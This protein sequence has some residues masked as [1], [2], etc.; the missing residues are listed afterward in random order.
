MSKIYEWLCNLCF[1]KCGEYG[2]LRVRKMIDIERSIFSILIYVPDVRLSDKPHHY[3]GELYCSLIQ[4]HQ[5]MEN[6]N[7]YYFSLAQLL[8]IPTSDPTVRLNDHERIIIK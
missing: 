4:H 1:W 7:Q 8:N 3:N 2:D 6:S 5:N